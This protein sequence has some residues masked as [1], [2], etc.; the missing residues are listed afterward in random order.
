MKQTSNFSVVTLCLLASIGFFMISSSGGRA[1]AANS[2]NTGAPGEP[3][4][5]KCGSCHIGGGFSPISESLL[6]TNPGSSDPI[7]AYVPGQ[8]YEV[9]L[10][11]NASGSPA[12]Y[13]FQMTSLDVSNTE[14]GSWSSPATNVQIETASLVGGRT[15]VEHKGVGSSNV[16]RVNW[17]AP[18]AGAGLVSFYHAANGVNGNGATSGD[19]GSLGAV[20]TLNA[21][22]G[23][24]LADAGLWDD[25]EVFPSL[26]LNGMLSLRGSMLLERRP[27]LEL[28]DGFGRLLLA[29]ASFDGS[30]A[31]SVADMPVGMGFVVLRDGQQTLVRRFVK[32]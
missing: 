4:G 2:G 20:T 31:I 15:Y 21:A 11:V 22:P 26:V 12:G 14:A 9:T 29:R 23:T 32:L 8:T 27:S 1:G 24:G 7:D 17:T 10:T 3:S 18:A 13:G 16:F 6:I 28:Y 25:L 5:Q 30:E 19:N